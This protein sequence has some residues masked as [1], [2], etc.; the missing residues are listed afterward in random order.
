MSFAIHPQR[1]IARQRGKGSPK[2]PRV[3]FRA[4]L[5][6]GQGP[7]GIGLSDWALERPSRVTHLLA[8]L[9]LAADPAFWL[10]WG[11]PTRDFHYPS[12]DIVAWKGN[13]PRRLWDRQLGDGYS[14]IL[15]DGKRLYFVHKRAASTVFS[16]L[17]PATGKTIWEQ[18]FEEAPNEAERKEMDPVHGNAPSSTPVLV[19]ERLFGVTFMGRLV[20]LH[21]DTGSILWTEQLWRQHGGTIVGYGYTN[22]PLP[23]KD[24]IIVP[25]GGK[26]AALMSFRQDS[27]KVVWSGETSDNAMSSPV[28]M[29]LAGK[30]QV[31]TVMLKEVLSVDPDNGKC[32]WRWPHANNTETN[33]SDAAAA[34]PDLVLISSA[35]DSGTRAIR[36]K[37]SA[38]GG[39][40]AAEEW[41]NKRIR[42]HQGNILVRGEHAYASSGDF[43][44]APLTAFRVQTG[45]IAWQDRSLAKA[46][47]VDLGKEVVAVSEDGDLSL[48]DLSPA[49]LKIL[50]KSSQLTSPAWT[51]PTIVGS[52]IFLR[53]R[54]SIVALDTA[55][56]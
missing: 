26:G 3:S 7:Q 6:F 40:T 32:L 4:K 11:G 13:G 34:G 15:M 52:M 22:S 25:V 20:A 36:V 29:T 9:F 46:V 5:A 43:G 8:L 16:A 12:S 30:P 10:Q 41:F 45:E 49:G 56:P 27:G 21:R 38:G 42:V 14:S 47:F 50:A 53:D 1:P 24:N 31:V 18:A 37:A 54:K 33:V 55:Q 51:P 23:F 28:L 2:T 19:G 17:E 48:I 39:F 35:Y 44:P